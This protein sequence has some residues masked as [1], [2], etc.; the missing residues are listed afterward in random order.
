M[1]SARRFKKVSRKLKII[2]CRIGVCFEIWALGFHLC[3]SVLI[4]FSGNT[5]KLE[6]E[7]PVAK[8]PALVFS[9]SPSSVDFFFE[10]AF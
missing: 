3:P 7:F 6:I 8:Y 9:N 10:I 4:E 5:A 1:E 2:L